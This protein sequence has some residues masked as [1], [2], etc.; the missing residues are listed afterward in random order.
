MLFNISVLNR[1]V[2]IEKI[3]LDGELSKPDILHLLS[4]SE[5]EEIT[6][7]GKIAKRIKKQYVLN[8]T[9][10]R[11]LIEFSNFCNKNCLYC[12]I[13]KNNNYISRYLMSREEIIEAARFAWENQYG[14]IVLQSGEQNKLRFEEILELL[15][16]TSAWQ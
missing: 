2:E 7:L 13:R 16:V 10:F 12:G 5:K 14:S 15:L 1:L 9:Y 6:I 8:K 3:A 4:L 11:G